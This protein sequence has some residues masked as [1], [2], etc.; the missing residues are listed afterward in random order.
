MIRRNSNAQ[1]KHLVDYL[2]YLPK[3]IWMTQCF[4]TGIG[5]CANVWDADEKDVY[6]ISFMAYVV[7]PAIN[8]NQNCPKMKIV[9]DF[10]NWAITDP[11]AK[12]IAISHDYASL[13]LKFAN[14][15]LNNVLNTM[16]CAIDDSISNSTYRS[17]F[18]EPPS[19]EALTVQGSGSNMME[20][21]LTAL[22]NEY[23]GAGK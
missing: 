10:F 8:S 7:V 2:C 3:S 17:I 18:N 13:P 5:L 19:S 1:V 23:S 20:P 4:L 6:P 21:L 14:S 15:V 16:N 22:L 11:A 12:Y 9:Y